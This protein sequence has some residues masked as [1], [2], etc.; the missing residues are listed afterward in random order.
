MANFQPWGPD[1]ESPL[2]C[3]KITA[4]GLD[5]AVDANWVTKKYFERPTALLVCISVRKNFG[6]SLVWKKIAHK[7]SRFLPALT[8]VRRFANQ[9][10][11]STLHHGRS[12]QGTAGLGRLLPSSSSEKSLRHPRPWEVDFASFG[13]AIQSQRCRFW[14]LCDWLAKSW[15]KKAMKTWLYW[16]LGA[17]AG[18]HLVAHSSRLSYLP[19]TK[20]ST[21]FQRVHCSSRMFRN[22]CPL[23]PTAST[24]N[25]AKTIPQ[26]FKAAWNLEPVGFFVKILSGPWV[27]SERSAGAQL[28]AVVPQL[29][30]NLPPLSM[31]NSEQTV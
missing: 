11:S 1:P 21:P 3:R 31:G 13:A 7:K 19:Q 14:H 26:A 25:S 20:E 5:D 10:W 28:L 9:I 16:I 23:V 18:S 30:S 17:Q 12:S 22:A 6:A 29:W 24:A 27:N 2:P 8:E 4:V 15:I